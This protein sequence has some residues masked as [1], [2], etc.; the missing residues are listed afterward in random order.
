MLLSTICNNAALYNITICTSHTSMMMVN[1]TT[2][3]ANV[4]VGDHENRC[5]RSG[6]G[7]ISIVRFEESSCVWFTV[8]LFPARSKAVMLNDTE[9]SL[10]TVFIH[11]VCTSCCAIYHQHRCNAKYCRKQLSL[12]T[13]CSNSSNIT[14]YDG[15]GNEFNHR[16][17]QICKRHNRQQQS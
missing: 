9:F 7:E 1:G 8:R 12:E 10:L 5:R 13:I 15:T 14:A 16:M 2:A 11:N 6:I 4:T 3:S 17:L